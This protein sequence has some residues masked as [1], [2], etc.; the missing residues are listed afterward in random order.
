MSGQVHH[1]HHHHHHQQ[2]QQQQLQQQQVPG[3]P[4]FISHAVRCL[5]SLGVQGLS[6]EVLRRAKRGVKDPEVASRMWRALYTL[7]FV[8]AVGGSLRGKGSRG[9]PLVSVQAAQDACQA[10]LGGMGYSRP[11]FFEAAKQRDECEATEPLLA[12]GWL[13]SKEFV[14][15]LYWCDRLQKVG[16]S[17]ALLEKRSSDSAWADDIFGSRQVA[18]AAS[19]EEEAMTAPIG[20]GLGLGSHDTGERQMGETAFDPTERARQCKNA[21]LASYGR[22]SGMLEEY[23][24]L[25]EG[26]KSLKRSI[27]RLQEEMM[28]LRDAEGLGRGRALSLAEVCLIAQPRIMAAHANKLERVNALLTEMI[29]CEE[30]ED[31][32]WRWLKAAA[33]SMS[34]QRVDGQLA[35]CSESSIVLPLL[36][37]RLMQAA[38][39]FGGLQE[40]HRLRDVEGSTGNLLQTIA[41]EIHDSGDPSISERRPASRLWSEVMPPEIR[42]ALDDVMRELRA[43]QG[44]FEEVLLTVGCPSKIDRQ[45]LADMR[46]SRRAFMDNALSCSAPSLA[47]QG[48]QVAYDHST[49]A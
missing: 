42:T 47:A 48:C 1:H 39:Q 30:Y 35:H 41:Q 5:A 23:E 31:T 34:T 6:A 45:G 20:L 32:W 33:D 44:V 25:E 29:A 19:C 38:D 2:Q 8:C 40:L 26:T 46:E 16:W 4:P 43:A 17:G 37:A 12:L 3:P 22:L 36:R 28:Q 24:L 13:M 15:K 9:L 7:S 14:F 10:F 27:S 49:S 21:L 11:Q 18:L